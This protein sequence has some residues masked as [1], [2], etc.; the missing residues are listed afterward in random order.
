M[1]HENEKF[2]ENLNKKKQINKD[3]R[4]RSIFDRIRYIYKEKKNETK[5]NI[6]EKVIGYIFFLKIKIKYAVKNIYDHF[7][8]KIS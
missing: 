5:F 6:F 4:C 2:K 1:S 3:Y 7:I 8:Y